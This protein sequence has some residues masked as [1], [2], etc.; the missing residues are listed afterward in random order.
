MTICHGCGCKVLGDYEWCKDCAPAGC[1]EAAWLE[2]SQ[3]NLDK[4]EI[5]QVAVRMAAAEYAKEKGR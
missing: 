1:D 5:E 4:A 2:Q 3:R